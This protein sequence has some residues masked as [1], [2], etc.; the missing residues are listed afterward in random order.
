MLESDDGVV[1]RNR[2][3]IDAS[4]SGGVELTDFSNAAVAGG[5][6][7]VAD[8][9]KAVTGRERVR[10]R[11]VSVALRVGVVQFGFQRFRR[12]EC[13]PWPMVRKHREVQ[14]TTSRDTVDET[15]ELRLRNVDVQIVWR[16]HCTREKILEGDGARDYG[17]VPYE[18]GVECGDIGY[19]WPEAGLVPGPEVGANRTVQCLARLSPAGEQQELGMFNQDDDDI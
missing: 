5:L 4:V 7:E 1:R 2:Y 8:I 3:D 10:A 13:L 11:R 6:G 15:V 16:P 14:P 12:M 19:E 17:A 18:K 9:C